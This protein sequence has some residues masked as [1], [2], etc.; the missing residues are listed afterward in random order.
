M[1]KGL[2]DCCNGIWKAWASMNKYLYERLM[3]WGL[4]RHCNKTT[5]WVF[6]NYWKHSNGRWTFYTTYGQN[7]STTLLPYNLG[8][9]KIRTRLS[10]KVNVFD[11]KNKELIRKKQL[12]KKNDLPYKK[13][14]IWRKQKAL[15]P[16]CDHY[17]NPLQPN[18]ID[19][20]HMIPRKG[21]V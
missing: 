7:K 6:N 18:M 15:C 17:L 16:V 12:A 11:L 19:I 10:Y 14:I 21:G 3:K 2:D 9:K 4:K 20:H 5:K 1:K 8:I 13:Q